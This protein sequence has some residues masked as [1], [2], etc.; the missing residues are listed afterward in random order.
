MRKIGDRKW[1][2]RIT[3]RALLKK[4]S[5]HCDVTAKQLKRSESDVTWQK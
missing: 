4:V 2:L 3:L 5:A 1:D